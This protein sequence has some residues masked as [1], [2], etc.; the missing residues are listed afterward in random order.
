MRRSLP[1]CGAVLGHAVAGA[2]VA[3]D[4]FMVRQAEHFAA[5]LEREART[6]R[7]EQIRRAYLLAL[8]RAPTEREQT[9][10]SGYATRYGMA[11]VCRLILNLNEFVFV[12]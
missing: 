4:R 3:H 12:D 2:G 9:L 8:G 11:A 10:L 7:A 5:R 6:G 1:R